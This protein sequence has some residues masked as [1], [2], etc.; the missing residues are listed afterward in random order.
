M[1]K[2]IHLSETTIEKIFGTTL[3]LKSKTSLISN[4]EPIFNFISTSVIIPV[5][6][7][8]FLAMFLYF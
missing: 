7:F 4:I 3:K 1:N 2:P 8:L 6:H 5:P